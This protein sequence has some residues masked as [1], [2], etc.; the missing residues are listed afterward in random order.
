MFANTAARIGTTESWNTRIEAVQKGGMAAILD[1]ILA[2]FLSADFRQQHPEETQKIRTM[3][4]TTHPTGYIGACAALREAD[5]RAKLHQIRTPSLIIGSAL[6]E[7]TPPLQSHELHEHIVG[8]QLHIFD[9]VA[10]LSN[11]ERPNEFSE[12]VLSFVTN[13]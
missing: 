12:R 4:E 3:I 11:V 6:D 1:M 5:L 8:S 9:D 10:H 13:A 2:R 7:S